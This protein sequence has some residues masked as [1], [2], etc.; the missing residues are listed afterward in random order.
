[1]IDTNCPNTKNLTLPVHPGVGRTP[2]AA[3]RSD[4]GRRHPPASLRQHAAHA[5]RRTGL[6][7]PGQLRNRKLAGLRPELLAYWHGARSSVH[8]PRWLVGSSKLRSCKK[9]GVSGAV[10]APRARRFGQRHRGGK[11]AAVR[12]RRVSG[13]W[14]DWASSAAASMGLSETRVSVILC[15]GL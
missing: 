9:A 7:H 6:T 8:G 5:Y 4:S 11:A 10:Q 1:M 2:C 3:L 14:P 15:S 13:H 12:A